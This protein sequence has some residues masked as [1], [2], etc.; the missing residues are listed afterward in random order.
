MT[1]R[2]LLPRRAVL[3]VLLTG[4]YVLAGRLG[5]LLAVVNDSA[6]AVWPPTGLA[7]ATLLLIGLRAWPVV[8]IGAFIVNLTTSGAGGA[9]A[10]IALGNT[11]EAVTGAWLVQRYAGGAAVFDSPRT[12]FRFTCLAA[13]GATA[14][15][16]TVGVSALLLGGLASKEQAGSIWFT[17]WLGDAVGALIVTPLVVSWARPRDSAWRPS[18]GIEAAALVATIAV[19]LVVVFGNSP[20]GAAHYPLTFVVAPVLLWSAFR[21]GIR[22]T[23]T[24]AAVVSGFALAGTLRGWGPFARSSPNESLLLLQAFGGLTTTMVLCVAAEVKRRRTIEMDIRTLNDALERSI[25]ERTEQLHVVNQRLVEAQRVAHVGSWE[26]DIHR[27]TLWWSEELYR[28]Y[29]VDPDDLSGYETYLTRLHPADRERVDG[30]V[31][32]ALADGR[33]FTFEHRIVRPDGSVRVVQSA[34]QVAAGPDGRPAR[35]LGIAHDITERHQAEEERAQLIHAQAARHEAEQTSRAKD[36]FVA[37]LSHELRTP[38]NAALGWAKILDGLPPGDPKG[39]RALDAI[40]RNL[41][42]QSR[43]VSDIVDVSRIT[44][45]GIAVE[46]KPVDVPALFDAAIET[47][48]EAATLRQV[49]IAV[50]LPD[51]PVSLIGDADRL[52]QVLWNLLSNGVRFGR[53]GGQVRLAARNDGDDVVLSVADDGPGID[54]AFLPYVFEPFRQADASPKRQ[55]DGLGLGLSIARH[56][57]EQHGGT[58]SAANGESGGAVFTVRLP[59]RRAAAS[60][61]PSADGDGAQLLDLG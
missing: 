11:L 48:R 19:V 35:M 27:N 61:L 14:I 39:A 28:I 32:Q 31:R 37:I 26:W 58:V 40:V 56:I 17:W 3:L 41:S 44:R 57:V 43:L 12:I 8:L 21:F 10:L 36:E 47:V 22:E 5:L 15:A 49:T 23:V 38:L 7:F 53:E 9:S 46:W 54:P 20:T 59:A 33:P 2:V 16:A 34:G 55:H 1:S 52:R 18:Q 60:P 6:S 30:T 45:G 24:A 51:Q 42:I 25:G 4:A 50:E 29:G 13:A